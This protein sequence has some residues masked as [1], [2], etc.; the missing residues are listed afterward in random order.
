MA[1]D[2][3]NPWFFGI[4]DMSGVSP[5]SGYGGSTDTLQPNAANTL[6]AQALGTYSQSQAKLAAFLP[7]LRQI[8][9]GW[10]GGSGGGNSSFLNLF[11]L[12]RTRAHQGLKDQF[13]EA[14]GA[15]T[16]VGPYTTASANLERGLAQ[17]E[18]G[19]IVDLLSRQFG[20][21]AG[22]LQSL[23]GGVLK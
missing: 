4:P 7:F 12:A 17:T 22:I 10:G 8:M 23:L 1:L 11:N 13:T 2:A 20:P 19:N 9:K 15:D 21:Q 16:L 6:Y 3:S 14:G 18:Q 5:T